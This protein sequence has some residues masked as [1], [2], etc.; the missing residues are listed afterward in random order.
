MNFIFQMALRELRSSW[1][2]LL[3]FFIC[4]AIGVCA[5]VA[6]RSM[7]QNVNRAIAGDARAILTADVQVDSDRPWTD[8]QLAIINQ[9][10]QAPRVTNRTETIESATMARPADIA[11]EAV[12]MV[13]LKGIESNYPLVG[14]F[15]L[16]DGRA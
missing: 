5:I 16:Q 2:R 14:E 9:V 13:E 11:N 10:M 8:E 4:I 3:F 6:L 12:M 7:I 1:R 15:K